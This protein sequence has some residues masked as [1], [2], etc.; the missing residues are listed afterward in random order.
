MTRQ[1]RSL[2]ETRVARIIGNNIRAVR[3]EIGIS[4]EELARWVGLSVRSISS[5]ESGINSPSA[6]NLARI[7]QSLEISVDRLYEGAFE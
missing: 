6:Y 7:S 4:Q 1:T 3:R 2:Q 5:Y